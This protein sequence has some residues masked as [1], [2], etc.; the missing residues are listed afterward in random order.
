MKITVF[1]GNQPRH[2]ALVQMLTS[3]S[4]E[5][6]AVIEASTVFPGRAK[7]WFEESDTMRLYFNKVRQAE[8]EIF[9]GIK[10]LPQEAKYIMLMHGDLN[11][12]EKFTL[13]STLDAD[14]F[15]I[16]GAS[17]IKGWLAEYL[18]KRRAISIHMGL[19]P[20]YR[21]SSC[22]FWAL[23]D[24]R[25]ECVGATIQL[26]SE[27]L[28]TGDILYHAIPRPRD[29]SPFLFTM[30]AV[31]AAQ[32]SLSKRIASGELFKMPTVKPLKSLQIRYSR[33]G[34]FTERAALEFLSMLPDIHLEKSKSEHQ[35]H[36]QDPYFL[37]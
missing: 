29:E 8:E 32:I 13:Q 27:G 3:I 33:A 37:D 22:N 16:F 17:Y 5:T 10:F 28:D 2:L 25:P 26:L 35:I 19:S 6:S 11:L 24:G 20:Y 30:R 18:I 36:L 12:A 14:L 9:G 7:G 23:Y 4:T 1:T 34:D 21:G 15:V 31:Q